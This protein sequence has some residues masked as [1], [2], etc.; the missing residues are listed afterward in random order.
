MRRLKRFL[1]LAAGLLFSLLAL[2]AL[3]PVW[4]P[5]VVSPLLSRFHVHY[6]AY[7]RRGF[8]RFAVKDIQY[9]YKGTMVKAGLAEGLLPTVWLWQKWFTPPARQQLFVTAR[10]WEVNIFPK[11]SNKP[12]SVYIT[13]KQIWP[14]VDRVR[15]W[16]P[17]GI[18]ERGVIR[19]A[20]EELHVSE[21]QWDHS[22]VTVTV[23]DTWLHQT[24]EGRI[25]L[26]TDWDGQFKLRP[27]RADARLVVR[28]P[29]A[30]LKSDLALL[31]HGNHAAISADFAQ[32]GLLPERLTLDAKSIRI[33][34]ADLGLKSYDELTGSVSGR[35]QDG[36][37]Q[38]DL[39]ANAQP[40]MATNKSTPPISVDF[41]ASGNTHSFRVETAK[42]SAPGI[43][44]ELSKPLEM[45][46]GGRML[47]DKAR[48]Q[49]FADVS[50]Q[51]WLPLT[52]EL[53]GEILLRREAFQ[54]PDIFFNLSGNNLAGF[55][56]APAEVNFEGHLIWPSLKINLL[57]LQF[58]NTS[59]VDAKGEM[60]VQTRRI[61]RATVQIDGPIL[62]KFLP[63]NS[64][65]KTLSLSAQF[66]GALAA[67]NHSGQFKM[68]G[69]STPGLRPLSLD[70][71]WTG[72]ALSITQL[73]ARVSPGKS[74]LTINGAA[75]RSNLRLDSATLES[76]AQKLSLTQ[77]AVLSW[78]RTGA[79][80]G[81]R[82]QWQPLLW[83]GG[84][85]EMDTAGALQWPSYANFSVGARDLALDFFQEFL[86]APVP[87]MEIAHFQST[88]QWSNGPVHFSAE[89]AARFDPV[90]NL[91]LAIT[92]LPFSAE[93]K[94]SGDE[95][96]V[97]VT[98]FTLTAAGAPIVSASG[99][100]PVTLDPEGVHVQMDEPLDLHASTRPNARFWSDLT[101]RQ[102][103]T[104]DAPS[105]DLN[106]MGTWRNPSGTLKLAARGIAAQVS[107]NLPRLNIS[108]L[109]SEF[110]VTPDLITVK[111]FEARLEKQPFT[112]HGQT[113]LPRQWRD[114]LDWRKADAEV[115]AT[116][117]QLAAF[118]K[119][120]PQ[121]LTSQGTLNLNLAASHGHLNGEL[122]ITNALS[123]PLLQEGS[124]QDLAADI[125]LADD[126]IKI[127]RCSGLVGGGLVI[128]TGDADLGHKEPTTGL[129]YFNV[130][131][132]GQNVPLARTAEII[133]R[134][135]FAVALSNK[136]G[137]EPVLTGT[138]TLLH[139]YYLSDPKLLVPNQ[140]SPD[141]RPPYF[142]IDTP[143]FADWRLDLSV[144]GTKFLQVHSPFFN[145]VI[146]ASFHLSGPLRQPIALGNIQ[147]NSGQIE[148][149]F[150]NLNVTQGNIYLTSANPYLPQLYISA[151]A[152][153]FSYDLR[154]Q[155]NG[156]ADQPN[157]EF[158]ST[159]GLSSDEI[160]LMLTTG[161]LPV[162][163]TSFS[164]EQRASRVGM[165]VGKN[166]LDQLGLFPGGEERLSVGSGEAF[167]EL[168]FPEEVIETYSA[169][170]RL[171]PRWSLI[172]EY[173][174]FG[175]SLG[176]KWLFYSK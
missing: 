84:T 164:T 83:R 168:V 63:D 65:Y 161:E 119:F 66:E 90:R 114:L 99:S 47:S 68:T 10:D 43:R 103:F 82:L 157:F 124:V 117:I 134:T 11:K 32:T 148:F 159:P 27:S 165:F 162:N 61:K 137:G 126:Q 3:L 36:R 156:P 62:Q 146:S 14:W 40:E 22:E 42:I 88:V 141:T 107:T 34:A 24:A 58:T 5:W 139:S 127:V 39:S 73:H 59:V 154:V 125:R 142:R 101:T 135:G 50:R 81:W 138:A 1:A 113:P 167:G 121:V 108:D 172:G 80:P 115:S 140:A 163:V 7:E 18:G 64:G 128:I 26:R 123:Q 78:R 2:T 60:D 109:N 45:T 111:H 51:P 153:A 173:D 106:V 55:G 169:E 70:A 129:P 147:I 92:N 13:M 102:R 170:Y 160:L 12:G 91:S 158:S 104:L 41:R 94:A 9:E 145:G 16:V 130:S 116:N 44:A 30:S 96:G 93:V 52:G 176:L 25:Y 56:V 67:L 95:R 120:A 4:F 86:F 152:R 98:R 122:T 33:A 8:T 112:G 75:D 48:L 15:R 144:A 23:S 35:W 100:V 77:P 166:T 6:S 20:G 97:N 174:P 133:L 17:K 155:V 53:D 28:K 57:N 149:P 19:F 37:F 46:F 110:V 87:A 49:L 72:Q 171:T 21:A 131:A 136:K 150:A 31:W 74:V 79:L 29:A 151:S 38:L 132:R 118:T 175:V 54:I 69:L 71:D 89:G 143:P 76:G 85:S 105:I